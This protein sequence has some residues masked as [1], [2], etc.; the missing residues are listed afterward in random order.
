MAI[1]YFLGLTL[2]GEARYVQLPVGGVRFQADSFESPETRLCFMCGVKSHFDSLL[3][4]KPGGYSVHWPR[5]QTD[6]LVAAA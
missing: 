5:R 6:N 4:A 3:S 1:F 2:A